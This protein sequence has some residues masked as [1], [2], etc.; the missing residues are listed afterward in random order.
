MEFLHT[1]SLEYLSPY[2]A[3]GVEQKPMKEL[4]LKE[5]IAA[6]YHGFLPLFSE[7]LA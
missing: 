1:L 3:L 7:A 4:L 6:E 5:Y 2:T